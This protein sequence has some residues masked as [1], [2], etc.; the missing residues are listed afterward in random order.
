MDNKITWSEI[1]KK[2]K[3]SNNNI[4]LR[5]KFVVKKYILFKFLLK[6]R[7]KLTNSEYIKQTILISNQRFILTKNDF[8][9]DLEENIIHLL[10]WINPHFK[11][12]NIYYQQELNLNNIDIFDKIIEEKL[13]NYELK[14]IQDYVFF[15]NNQNKS[16]KKYKFWELIFKDEK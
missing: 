5:N 10:L 14:N 1:K 16:K 15:E 7:F 6:H 11:D 3:L 12:N 9:Y 8:P 2:H 4:M 13:K